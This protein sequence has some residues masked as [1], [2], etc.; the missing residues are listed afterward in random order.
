MIGLM[1]AADEAEAR[2][3][4]SAALEIICRQPLDEDGRLFWRPWRITGLEQLIVLEPLLPR[5]VTSRWILDQAA[6]SFDPGM[7]R[8]R[9]AA[10]AAAIELRGGGGALPGVD[11]AD[12]MARVLDGDW[13]YRQLYLYD[14]GGLAAFLR[15]VAAP[16]LLAGADRIRDWVGAPM[17]ALRLAARAPA[18]LHWTDLGTGEPVDVPDLGGGAL[19]RLGETVLGRLVPTSDGSMFEG[20][21]LPVPPEVAA[22]VAA[23]PGDWVGALRRCPDLGGC[24]TTVMRGSHLVTD[25]PEVVW[26]FATLEWAGRL[27]P[28]GVT[29][30][31]LAEAGAAMARAALRG[32]L[33]T[34]VDA[35]GLDPWPCVAAALCDPRMLERLAEGIRPADAPGLLALADRLFGPAA[36]ICR[37]LASAAR[38]AA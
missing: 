5:W 33:E 22:A 36:A 9:A 24:R 17:R 1:R 37:D 2:G 30:D 28:S 19:V 29:P 7:G 18:V 31:V 14:H 6:Q 26:Q 12:A 11:D 20:T 4:P 16:D 38:A 8:G 34:D 27:D 23:D 10:L 21:P 15:G 13:V 3:D 35:A 32:D 25:V